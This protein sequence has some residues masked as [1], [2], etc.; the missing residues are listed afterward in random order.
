MSMEQQPASGGEQPGEREKTPRIGAR[1]VVRGT[2]KYRLA[3][4]ILA[5]LYRYDGARGLKGFIAKYLRGP[6]FRFT[7]WMRFSTALREAPL[8]YPLYLIT[9]WQHCRLEYKFGIVI[10][11]A[12]CIGPGLFIGHF[13]GIVVH[14]DAVI[15]RNCNLSHG[16]TIGQT[17]RGGRQGYPVIGD[18]VYLESGC[19]VIGRVII[20]SNVAI[21]AIEFRKS[22]VT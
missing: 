3:Y 16:V 14:R 20:G 10:P 6:G 4:L 19:K 22:N 21:G 5:D 9:L 15:G 8:L 7:F 12:T 1:T 18:S 11:C 17:N 13:G 2:T